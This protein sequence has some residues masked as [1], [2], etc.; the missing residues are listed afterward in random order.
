MVLEDL[1]QPAGDIGTRRATRVE[2]APH[3]GLLCLTW[4]AVDDMTYRLQEVLS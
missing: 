3:L 4:M 2:D 1:G